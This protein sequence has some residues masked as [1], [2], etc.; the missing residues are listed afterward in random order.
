MAFSKVNMVSKVSCHCVCESDLKSKSSAPPTFSDCS[1]T[2]RDSLASLVFS[3]QRPWEG[4]PGKRVIWPWK[5]LKGK[6]ESQVSHSQWWDKYLILTPLPSRNL[7]TNLCK[8]SLCACVKAW[9]RTC[10]HLGIFES[11][12]C[13]KVTSST[14]E[15]M[16]TLWSGPKTPWKAKQCD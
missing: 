7:K 12:A 9:K 5:R 6:K 10:P 15:T 1:D 4:Y 3:P 14:L 8:T 16:L 2:A 11:F 13:C